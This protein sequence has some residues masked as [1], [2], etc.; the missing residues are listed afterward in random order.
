MQ[1]KKTKQKN[2]T[3]VPGSGYSA[4]VSSRENILLL[5]GMLIGSYPTTLE[6]TPAP[7]MKGDMRVGKIFRMGV[8]EVWPPRDPLKKVGP[9]SYSITY[10]YDLSKIITSN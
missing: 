6:K 7:T 4:R 8:R 9:H 10:F 5:F 1:P 3:V 2:V